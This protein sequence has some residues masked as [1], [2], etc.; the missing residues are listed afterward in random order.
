MPPETGPYAVYTKDDCNFYLNST[1]FAKVLSFF[2][3]VFSH[4]DFAIKNFADISSLSLGSIGYQ[5]NNSKSNRMSPIT[6]CYIR[7]ANATLFPS[8]SEYYIDVTQHESCLTIDNLHPPGSSEW[9]NFSY[10][11][12]LQQ[13]HPDQID[14]QS[15]LVMSIRLPLRTILLDTLATFNTPQCYDLDASIGFNNRPHSGEIVVRMAIHNKLIPCN[16]ETN[17]F[18]FFSTL[19]LIYFCLFRQSRRFKQKERLSQY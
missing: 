7:Y 18:L 17:L 15:L 12:Y 11:D 2:P 10:L 14:F 13:N 5:V 1:Q 8:S 9:S 19:F 6:I 16:G 4:I 3:P